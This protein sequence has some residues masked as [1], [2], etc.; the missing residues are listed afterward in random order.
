MFGVCAV[1]TIWFIHG[2][3]FTNI[4]TYFQ[5]GGSANQTVPVACSIS[6]K[7]GPM[8]VHVRIQKLETD[9]L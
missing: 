5:E 7:V 4:T 3:W 9:R 6:E 8:Y 2:E 1:K